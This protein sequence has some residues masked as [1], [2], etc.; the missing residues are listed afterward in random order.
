MQAS[1]DGFW[2][3]VQRGGLVLGLTLAGT[4]GTLAAPPVLRSDLG[5]GNPVEALPA[6]SPHWLWVNDIV[7]AHMPDGKAHLVDGDSGKYLGQLNTG[8]G[9]GRMLLSPDGATIYSPETYFSRGTRGT[10]QD[11]VA[12]YDAKTLEPTGETL[13]PPKRSSNLAVSANAQLTDDGRFLLIYFFNPAQS[14]GVVD[15]TARKWVGEI[16][17]PGCA[18][19]YPAAPRAFFSLCADGAVQLINLNEQGTLSKQRRIENLLAVDKDPVDEEPVRYQG[20]WLFSTFAGSIVPVSA[21][22][23][24]V[25]AGQPWWL[26]T[27][28]ERAAQW[29]PGGHQ[30]MALSPALNRLY[31]LMLKGGP[32][33]HKDPAQEVWVYD[34]ATHAKIQRIHLQGLASSILV[35][36]DDKPLLYTAFLGGSDIGVYDARSGKQLRTIHEVATT[37]TL[38]VG[39]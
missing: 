29:R 9:Y 3:G 28:A 16:E 13:I 15:V 32:D 1:I 23:Q 7:F 31:V 18:L 4:L 14:V 25:T 11:I 24:A 36:R 5:Q 35:T 2:R 33:T 20:S 30:K 34:L 37:P 39:R 17:T 26:T 21:N 12:Y 10:R 38:L 8:F 22:A 6:A 27:P 19:V